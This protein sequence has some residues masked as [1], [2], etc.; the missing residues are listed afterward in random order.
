MGEGDREGDI[1]AVAGGTRAFESVVSSHVAAAAAA[2]VVLAL[3]SFSLSEG[4]CCGLEE[5]KVL[6]F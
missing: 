3:W 6:G 4:L 1:D 5:P 2:V